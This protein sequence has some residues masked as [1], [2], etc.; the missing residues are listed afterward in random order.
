MKAAPGRCC[1]WVATLGRT[2]VATDCATHGTCRT[3]MSRGY[4]HAM[5]IDPV[6]E[7]A[8]GPASSPWL[9]TDRAVISED[10]HPL[11]VD[12]LSSPD[13]FV[14]S[15]EIASERTKVTDEHRVQARIDQRRDGRSKSNQLGGPGIDEE[16][17]ELDPV[18]VAGQLGRHAQAPTIVGDIVGHQVPSGR[19]AAHLI[20]TP[21]YLGCVPSM[22]PRTMRAWIS[23]VRRQVAWY[24]NTGWRNGVWTRRS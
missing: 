3:A 20:L 11:I 5:A 22:T 13:D 15:I 23:M 1:N 2:A 6:A 7:S 21:T 17:A 16:D 8:S 14:S 9:R 24:P 18:T 10:D 12:R 19:V 4:T